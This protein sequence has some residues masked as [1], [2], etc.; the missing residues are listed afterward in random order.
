MPVEVQLAIRHPELPRPE[1]LEKWALSAMSAGSDEPGELCVRV[2]GN[3]ESQ[4]LN[5]AYRGV[6]K[7]TNV[8]SFPADIDVPEA[9]LLGDVVIC[10]PVVEFEAAEQHKNIDDHY[11]HM[12]VHGTLHLLGYDHESEG[13][14][15]QM[16]QLETIILDG[17][18]I[19]DPYQIR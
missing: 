1:L 4:S 2:V 13:E 18:G 6:N 9:N 10:A 17:L 15:E 3:E 16:E 11:A 7:P 8:L 19:A 14:A 12:V 5:A